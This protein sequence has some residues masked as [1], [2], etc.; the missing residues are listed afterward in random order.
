MREEHYQWLTDNLYVLGN[1]RMTKEQS[2]MVFNIYNDITNE[3]KP[4]TSCGRCVHNIKKRI[5]VEYDK[6][7]S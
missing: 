6:K 4:Q 1:V 5:K 2:T 7:R 3:N